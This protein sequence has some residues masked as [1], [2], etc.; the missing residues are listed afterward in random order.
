M[1]AES[2]RSWMPGAANFEW[3]Q[4]WLG[5]WTMWHV[6]IDTWQL[7]R[8]LDVLSG[9]YCVAQGTKQIGRRGRVRK[10]GK[11]RPI[12]CLPR[13]YQVSSAFR[14][15]PFALL[16]LHLACS[17]AYKWSISSATLAQ[18]LGITEPLGVPELWIV[19]HDRR[20]IR[21]IGV[22]ERSS[23]QRFGKE[24]ERKAREGEGRETQG[25]A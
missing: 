4:N 21:L 6:P 14:D 10:P 3:Q 7:F 17:W 19:M 11:D 25:G 18:R 1:S 8:I 23:V 22:A 24:G 13:S 20:L 15:H 5:S 2:R 12:G 9:R 16:L